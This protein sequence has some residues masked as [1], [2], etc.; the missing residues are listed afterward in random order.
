MLLTLFADQNK[1]ITA[2]KNQGINV[3][4]VLN[5]SQEISSDWL[6]KEVLKRKEQLGKNNEK[7]GD[8]DK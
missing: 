5:R 1:N 7:I 6:K 4:D 8:R 3:T 2:V